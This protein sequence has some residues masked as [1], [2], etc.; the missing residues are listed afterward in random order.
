MKN[1]AYFNPLLSSTVV[2]F[3][4]WMSN[5]TILIARFAFGVKTMDNAWLVYAFC[6]LVLRAGYISVKYATF[7]PMKWRRL[8]RSS[9]KQPNILSEILLGGPWLMQGPDAI[10]D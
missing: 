9:E 8:T 2:A 10:Y 1:F 3:I 4:Y 6:G 5:L 7:T